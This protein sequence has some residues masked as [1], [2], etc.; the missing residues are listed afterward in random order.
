MKTITYVRILSEAASAM[1]TVTRY[2]FNRSDREPMALEPDEYLS[3][4]HAIDVFKA[5]WKAMPDKLKDDIPAEVEA[6]YAEM[7]LHKCTVEDDG[8]LNVDGKLYQLQHLSRNGHILFMYVFDLL[9]EADA[10]LSKWDA[11]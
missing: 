7:Y 10:A 1:I 11:E 3:I 4:A 2:F 8:S 5:L 6:A 9:T